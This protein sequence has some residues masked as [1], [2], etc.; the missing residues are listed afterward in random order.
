MPIP[1][2]HL[3]PGSSHF[4]IR[5]RVSRFTKWGGLMS[6]QNIKQNTLYILKLVWCMSMND[7]VMRV[8][9]Y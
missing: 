4:G 9:N 8:V 7:R 3:T 2:S 6:T 5:L 1:G